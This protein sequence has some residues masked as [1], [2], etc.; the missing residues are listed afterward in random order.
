MDS[1]AKKL[2]DDIDQLLEVGEKLSWSLKIIA[3][4]AKEIMEVAKFSGSTSDFIKKFPNF[5]SQYQA[6]YSESIVLIKQILP[7]RLVDFKSHYEYPGTRKALDV[8]NYRINDVLQKLSVTRFNGD[9]IV[10]SSAAI[11]HLDQQISIVRAA[12]RR[13]D[14]S[15][16]DIRKIVQADLFDGEIDA[17]RELFKGKFLRAAGAIAG[18]VLERHLGQVCRDRDIKITKKNPTINDF[19]Q[20]L[21][22]NEIIGIPEW[23]HISML[24]DIRNICDHSKGVEPTEAQLNDLINGVD[25]VIKTVF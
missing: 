3:F 19:N 21:K 25:K 5:H 13:F 22:D 20:M 10:D 15:I 1:S 12:R 18:V 11:T 17:A 2:K 14:S 9:I 16:F 23:R 4:G 7:D 24:A 8:V 6:W